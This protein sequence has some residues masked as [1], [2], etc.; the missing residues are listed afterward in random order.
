MPAITVSAVDTAN[1]KLTATAHGL[2]TG[3]RFRVRNFGGALPT[4]LAAVTDYFAIRV[5]NDNLKAATSSANAFAGT[6]VNLTGAGSGVNTIEYG[7]PYCIPTA[8]AAAGTQ[9]K[10]ANDNGAWSALVTLY[11]LLTGQSQS[12]FAG[13]TFGESLK[14]AGVITPTALATAV[15]NDDMAPTGGATAN[16]IRWATSGGAANLGGLDLSVNAYRDVIL[17]NIGANNITLVHQSAGSSAQFR[18]SLANSANVV[19]RPNGAIRL[20]YDLT[21]TCWRALAI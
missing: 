16:V 10:S 3:D 20:W 5:D 2:V 13:W 8:L 7:L 19:V 18:F 14:M 17:V 9:I 6:A 1:D 4:G 12:V 21:S 11:A 15:P